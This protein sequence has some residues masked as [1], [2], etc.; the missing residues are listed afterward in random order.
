MKQKY[1]DKVR[2]IEMTRNDQSLPKLNSQY[3]TTNYYDLSI[4]RESEAWKV[5]L[6]LKPLNEPLEKNYT[7]TLF[8]KHIEEPKAF[9]AVINIEQIGWIELGYEKWNNRMRVWEFL[10]K[11]EL[12][13]MGIGSLLMD[14]AVKVAKEKDARMLVLETQSCNV[15]AINFYL[16]QGFNLIGFDSAAYSNE[17]IKKRE[18]RL[19]LGLT[20]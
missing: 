9:A 13:R 19:E 17:D 8:E 5:E 6:T 15:P 16:K 20:L 4:I 12:R 7:G 2:I 18:V 11:K 3:Q 1:L 14:F 10:V